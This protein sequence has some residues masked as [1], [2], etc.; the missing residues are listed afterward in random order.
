MFFV[1]LLNLEPVLMYFENYKI[2]QKIKKLKN[3]E[4]HEDLKIHR[5]HINSRKSDVGQLRYWEG[6]LEAV[7]QLILQLYIILINIKIFI[8][9]NTGNCIILSIIFYFY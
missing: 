1:F 6:I 9:I 4:N 7:P 3:N 2:L 8:N 5:E